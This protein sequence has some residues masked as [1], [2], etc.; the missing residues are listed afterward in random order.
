MPLDHGFPGSLPCSGAFC[1]L[2]SCIACACRC[3]LSPSRCPL[4]ATID[5]SASKERHKLL[6]LSPSSKLNTMSGATRGQSFQGIQGRSRWTMNTG[7]FP[8]KVW[9]GGR[10][11]TVGRRPACLLRFPQRLSSPV[12]TPDIESHGICIA[13]R[14]YMDR[15]SRQM[16]LYGYHLR[17]S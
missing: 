14:R 2:S 15:H 4:S 10:L 16:S 13:T 1:T 5:R 7:A 6:F 9:Q 8:V 11:P 3:P 12:W 17:N